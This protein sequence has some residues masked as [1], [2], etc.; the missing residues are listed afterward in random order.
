[1][2]FERS[3]HA[4]LLSRDVTA[5]EELAT[6][7]LPLVHH[8]VQACART[9]GI[10]DEAPINDAATESVL[11]YI[12]NPEKFNATKSSL[13]GYLKLAAERDLSNFLAKDRRQRRGEQLTDD[14]EVAILH[15]NRP[16]EMEK[17]RRD[18][19][20]EILQKIEPPRTTMDRLSGVVTTQQDRKLLELMISGER[21]TGAFASVLEILDLSQAEQRKIVKKHKDRLKKQLERSGGTPRG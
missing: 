11:N 12:R 16:S 17:I 4:R 10:Y 1:M 15:G 14:V 3:I 2:E 7:Y 21:K 20:T 13:L 5:S 8:H 9:R 18:A 6:R 19:E